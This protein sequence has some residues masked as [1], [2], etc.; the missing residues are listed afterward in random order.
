MA[1]EELL[2]SMGLTMVVVDSNRQLELDAASADHFLSA[3]LAAV[4]IASF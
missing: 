4:E 2:Q 3:Q 1:V